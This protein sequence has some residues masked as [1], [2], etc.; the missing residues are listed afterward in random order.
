M[1]SAMSRFYQA[2]LVLRVVHPFFDS[3]R[4]LV[5]AHRGGA[6][7]AP[8]NTCAA[9]DRG[10][11]LGADGLELDVRLS[12]DVGKPRHHD[13]TLDRPTDLRGPLASFEAHELARADAGYGFG[14]RDAWPFRG[15]G[16]GIPRLDSVLSRYPETRL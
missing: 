4:P 16:I 8:E 2:R 5:F 7:L 13:R 1:G 11:A 14:H 9:F 10:L 6:G 15:L 3:A 12:R